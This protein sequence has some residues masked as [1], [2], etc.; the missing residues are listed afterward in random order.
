MFKSLTFSCKKIRF[1]TKTC[2]MAGNVIQLLLCNPIS[3]IVAY[4][5]KVQY[6]HVHFIFKVFKTTKTVNTTIINEILS[7][8]TTSTNKMIKHRGFD[9]SNCQKMQF[10]MGWSISFQN[11]TCKQNKNHFYTKNFKSGNYVFF[12]T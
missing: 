4:L 3:P 10:F 5:L 11:Q 2:F 9:I 1:K 12:T 6:L 7:F 8:L